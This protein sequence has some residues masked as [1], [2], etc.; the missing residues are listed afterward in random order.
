[1]NITEI[2]STLTMVI[3]LPPQTLLERS[4]D[5]LVRMTAPTTFATRYVNKSIIDTFYKAFP[6]SVSDS[7]YTLPL[8]NA[9]AVVPGATFDA[10]YVGFIQ[11]Y[12]SA[13]RP[14]NDELVYIESMRP[15]L[16][17]FLA[18][19]NNGIVYDDIEPLLVT[20]LSITDP[21]QATEAQA[22][23]MIQYVIDKSTEQNFESNIDIQRIHQM[24]VS[25]AAS[26]TWDQLQQDLI[27]KVSDTLNMANRQPV[28]IRKKTTMGEAFIIGISAIFR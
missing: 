24:I 17:R 2:K 8:I 5:L 7:A 22:D 23:S 1:M 11:G 6:E 10:S 28:V 15:D 9:S 14:L 16:E 18:T 27:D 13:K 26:S 21:Y 25:M 3:A 4:I 19:L 12:F 20:R